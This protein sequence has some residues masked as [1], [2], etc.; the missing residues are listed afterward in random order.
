MSNISSSSISE[1][2][3]FVVDFDYRERLK[4]DVDTS[5]ME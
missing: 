4:S 3:V 1:Y 5:I 2:V